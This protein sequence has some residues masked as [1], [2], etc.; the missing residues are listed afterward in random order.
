MSTTIKID[1]AQYIDEDD[2]LT[3]AA[4]D[5]AREH[6]LEGWDLDPRWEDDQRD[7]ILLTVPDWRDDPDEVAAARGDYLYDLAKDDALT[8]DRGDY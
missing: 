1:A 4:D 6:S 8:G 3:A 7:V 5:Y 2:C